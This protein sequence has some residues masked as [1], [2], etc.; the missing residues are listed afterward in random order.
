ME[1]KMNR[2]IAGF[3][4]LLFFSLLV[5]IASS[6]DSPAPTP[7]SS[8]KSPSPSPNSS[9]VSSPPAPTPTPASSPHPDSP[10]APS[11]ENSPSSSPSPSPDDAADSQVSHAG[12]GDADDKSSGEGMSSGKKAGIAVGVIAS[13]CVVGLGAMV[14][15]KRRQN[16]QRSEYGYTAR[17]ELL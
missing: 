6:A 16:I 4:V 3:S 13:V 1:T 17:R 8:L 14:Y 11:P 5:N 9:P 12:V 2:A 7:D 10:P 15:K